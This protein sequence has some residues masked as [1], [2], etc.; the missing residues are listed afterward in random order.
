MENIA[1]KEQQTIIDNIVLG[2][3]VCSISVAGSGKSTTI[4]LVANQLKKKK[5]LHMTYN[6]SLRKEFKE[7]VEYLKID[8]IDVHTFHSFAVK[9][10][11][12]NAFTDE[13]IRDIVIKKMENIQDITIP[14][15]D[16]VVIDECQDLTPLYYRFILYFLNLLKKK[17]QMVILGDPLQSLYEFKGSDSRFLTFASEIWSNQPFLQTSG[18]QFCSLKTSYRLTNQMSEFINT[19]LY[20]KKFIDTCRSGA[21]INYIRNN[22]YSIEKIII[23]LIKRIIS[24]GDLPSDIFIL[25]A[26]VSGLNSQLKKME[27]ALTELEIPCYIPYSDVEKMDERVIGGKVVFSTFHTVKG[28]QRKHVFVIGFDNSYF[29]FYAK[30]LSKNECPNTLYVA[31][32]RSTHHLYVIENNNRS[33]DRPLEFLQLGHHAM[34]CKEFIDFK[35]IAQTIFYEIAPLK[36]SKVKTHFVTISKIIKFITEEDLELI[37]PLLTKIFIDITDKKDKNDKKDKKDKNDKNNYIFDENE[38]PNVIELPDSSFEDVSDINNIAIPCIFYDSLREEIKDS[39]LYDLISTDMS[40]MKSNEHLYLKQLFESIHPICMNVTDYLF[41]SNFYIAVK[42]KLYFKLKH[43]E[44]KDCTWLSENTIKKCNQFLY[45][46]LINNSLLQI[47]NDIKH[48]INIIDNEEEKHV[49]I[50]K[51]LKDSFSSDC[52]FRFSARIDFITLDALWEVKC[53]SHLSVEHFLHIVFYA[54]LWKNIYPEHTKQFKI[55]NIKSSQV[56]ELKAT[57]EELTL[58]VVT[59]LNSKYKEEKISLTDNEF[60]QQFSY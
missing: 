33:T 3:N 1:S 5:I 58:I 14:C 52:K 44:K 24:E 60:L 45:H 37:S 29:E 19:V 56:F 54:W 23:N 35:G 12:P 50:D 38:I 18:F 46:Y 32:T 28:R 42:E 15:Y 53:S 39:N 27:N 20:K 30:N 41:L 13:G 57:M 36:Q 25:S 8:N 21:P 16:I 17:I 40:K 2:N 22:N 4:L 55:L 6:S 7:K 9:Y 47:Q 11:L 26:S 51:I 49:Y 43:I 59:L 34:K 10:F 31:C 48:E